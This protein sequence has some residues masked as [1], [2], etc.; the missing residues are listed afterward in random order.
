M[1]QDEKKDWKM[2]WEALGLLPVSCLLMYIS[3]SRDALGLNEILYC[4]ILVCLS[5]IDLALVYLLVR[6]Y[7]GKKK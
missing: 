4:V 3:L 6:K 2:V 1:K 7:F 5:I